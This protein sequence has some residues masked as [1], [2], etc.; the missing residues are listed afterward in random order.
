LK[1]LIKTLLA[2]KS[3]IFQ[4]AINLFMPPLVLLITT[5]YAKFPSEEQNFL[6]IL[7][8]FEK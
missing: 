7:I 5:I 8:D 1:F 4:I 3:I 6:K 2:A